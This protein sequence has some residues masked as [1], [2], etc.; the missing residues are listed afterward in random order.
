MS[1]RTKMLV[2]KLIYLVLFAIIVGAFVYLSN[3]YENLSKKPQ[4]SF[5]HYYKKIET[6]KYEVINAKTLIKYFKDDQKHLIFI[7]DNSSEWSQKYASLLTECLEELNTKASYYD[8]E[9]DKTQK[10]SNYYK[11]RERLKNYLTT[12]D[13][14]NSNLLAPSFYIINKGRIRY[15][16]IDTVAMK[17]TTKV[18]S[19]WSNYNK[20]SFK[21]EI[22][23]NIKRYYLNN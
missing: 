3:K 13:E 9:S 15:Y 7:G 22:K 2:R 4:L 10:N 1:I 11:I 5:N 21:K 12:T 17:N 14:S 8:L 20:E 18:S 6:D 23:Y 19:Y 16:N